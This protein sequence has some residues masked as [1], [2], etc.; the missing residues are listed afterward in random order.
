[1]NAR[2]IIATILGGFLLLVFLG[3]FRL[4]ELLWDRCARS[5]VFAILSALAITG[6]GWLA[7]RMRG[8]SLSLDFLVGYP[9]FGALCFLIGTVRVSA[10]TMLPLVLIFGA[11]GLWALVL[12]RRAWESAPP[13][14]ASPLTIFSMIAIAFVIIGAFIAAQS[15]PASL[16]ELAY[17]LAVPHAWAVDG[18]A[19]DL[20]LISHS[21][22]P[23]GIE[24]A[25]L[26]LFVALDQTEGGIS[27]H[28]VHLLA[29][30]ATMVLL[31]RFAR[32][33]G[34]DGEHHWLVVAAIVTTPAL[35][36]TAG[37]S[38]VDWPLAG[39][40]LA[41]ISSLE[42]NDEAT[43]AAAVAAGLLTKYTF[44][45]LLLVALLVTRRWR[46]AIPGMI[47]GSVF[48][49]RNLVLTGN[50]IAPFFSSLAPHVTGYRAGSLLDYLF[51]DS[52]LD[53]SLG[54]ALIVLCVLASGRIAWSFLAVA[55]VLFFTAPSSR[56]L[57]PFLLIPALTSLTMF[58][59]RTWA[60]RVLVGLL[61]VAIALQVWLIAIYVDRTQTF[62]L[63]SGRLSD[64]EFM[65][66]ARPSYPA[67]AWLNS[68]L[69]HGSR[70]LVVGLNETYWFLRST[71]GGGNFDSARMSAYL[72][73]DTP[74]ALR[75][76]LLG[77]GITHVA[78]LEQPPPT[79]VDS[80]VDERE[81]RLNP[82]AQRMLAMTLDRFAANVTARGNVTL[83]TLR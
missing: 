56:I 31:L 30:L 40:T 80:K 19:S 28:F 48:F 3:R 10:W 24:S 61:V 6:V 43:I 8:G 20:P 72:T 29:A 65:K 36:L 53:E 81:T 69:P 75:Q 32:R 83:F 34:G 14:V 39:I 68:A 12:R 9:I 41:L 66:H 62:T 35:A 77:D 26:P 74:D 25:D 79:L 37:W 18:R 21:Y 17:H 46:P 78:V 13:G 33:H 58:A 70:T 16:D 44:I 7:R 76:R 63:I 57:L 38:L 4:V 50:P 82:D 5:L 27:S 54:I 47:V 45:P 49:I 1:V 60:R 67:I 52:F 15:P 2:R 23:L 71:R 55:V 22:F 51:A 42:E 73:A 11:V 64:E 59:A